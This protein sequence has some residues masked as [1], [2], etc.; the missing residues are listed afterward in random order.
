MVLRHSDD[1]LG[2]DSNS[3]ADGGVMEKLKP[4]PWCGNEVSFTYKVVW[5]SIIGTKQPIAHYQIQCPL[6][7]VMMTTSWPVEVDPKIKEF[8]RDWN[9]MVWNEEKGIWEEKD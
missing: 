3:G 9:N 6:H 1:C 5:E 4:C 8:E 2:G 7:G